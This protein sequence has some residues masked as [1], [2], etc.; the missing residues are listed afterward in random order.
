MSIIA[1]GLLATPR[2][3]GQSSGD[4]LLAL[5]VEAATRA[6]IDGIIPEPVDRPAVAYPV[7]RVELSDWIDPSTGSTARVG[8]SCEQRY[9]AYLSS[10]RRLNYLE[11]KLFN[12]SAGQVVIAAHSPEIEKMSPGP[13]KRVRKPVPVAGHSGTY[14]PYGSTRQA[15]T[16]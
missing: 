3:R 16:S 5:T 9:V 6:L 13:Y 2:A 11:L 8:R 7:Q 15:S 10:T 1:G 14:L 12:D 4:A